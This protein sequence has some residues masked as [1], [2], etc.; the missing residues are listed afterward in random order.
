M[1]HGH[2]RR[3]ETSRE[4]RAWLNIKTRCYNERHSSFARYGQRGVYVCARWRD[5]FV[6]FLSDMGRKPS[7]SHSIDRADGHGSYTCGKCSDCI[8]RGAPANCRWS[9][10]TEQARN[11]RTTVQVT[12]QGVTRCL[13]EWAEVLGMSRNAL[14]MRLSRARG[15]SPA[16]VIAR[17]LAQRESNDNSH[18]AA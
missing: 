11:Q 15:M 9:T 10:P 14:W 2:A 17:I 12:Y 4:Y 18:R 3:A 6:A 13:P 8:A 5:S 1:T 7:R 16:D